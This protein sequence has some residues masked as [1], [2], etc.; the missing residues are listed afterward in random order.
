M[1]FNNFY[2]IPKKKRKIINA[3]RHYYYLQNLQI[4]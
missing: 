1:A 4:Y 3:I 2:S